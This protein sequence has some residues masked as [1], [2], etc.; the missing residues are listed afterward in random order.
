MLEPVGKS[1]PSR[2]IR[3]FVILAG[4]TFGQCVLYGPSLVG[5]K[6]LLPLDILAQQNVYTPRTPENSGIEAQNPTLTDNVYVY[7]P[8]RHFLSSELRAGRLPM[9]APFQ[10]G[11]VPFIW[12][13]FSPFL[14]LQSCVS[15]PGVL[16]WVQLLSALV[17]GAGAYLFFRRVLS[18]SFWPAAF[19]AWCYPLTGFFVF[20]LGCPTSLPVCW[21]PWLFLMVHFV[22]HRT[23]PL[24]PVGLALTTGLVLVSGFPDVAAQVLLGSGLFGLWQCFTLAPKHRFSFDVVKA[25]TR[26]AACW[27]LGFLVAAPYLLPVVEYS[28]T[29]SRMARRGAGNEERPPIG[30]AAVPQ[31]VLPDMYGATRAGTVRSVSDH[32]AESTAA[33]YA[34]VLATL[35]V[36]PL[37]FCSKRHLRINLFW[38]ALCFFGLAWCANVPGLVQLLRLPGLNMMSHNRLVFLASFAIISL[39]AIGLDALRLGLVT[40]KRWVWVPIGLLGCLCLWSLYCIMNLPEPIQTQLSHLILQGKQFG[41]VHDLEGVERVQNWFI[42]YYSMAAI[43]CGIGL[44][45][46]FL[47][48]RLQ[49]QPASIVTVFGALM[50]GDLLW[51]G[52]GRIAQCAPNLY[53]PRIPA[54]EWVANSGPGRIMGYGCLPATLSEMAGLN[55]IRGHDAVEP[56]RMVELITL[57]SEGVSLMPRYA[58]TMQV[59]PKAIIAPSGEFQLSPIMAMLGL[60]YVVLRGSPPAN[61]SP[62][63]RGTDYWIMKNPGAMARV[64][65]PKRVELVAD[66]KSRLQKMSA[67]SFNP[68]EIAYVEVPVNLPVSCIG[69]ASVTEAVPTQITVNA[70][71]ETPGLVVLA[72]RWDKGWRAYLDGKDEPILIANHAIRGVVV[73]AG[74]HRLVFRYQPASF[75]WGLRMAGLAALLILCWFAVAMWQRKARMPKQNTSP[76]ESD[77]VAS[78]VPPD[79]SLDRKVGWAS[80]PPLQS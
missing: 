61:A 55:D 74:T 47:L 77:G 40:W 35:L 24:A 73:P 54:L 14:L 52:Y 71:M 68:A 63:F 60:R 7:E 8:N 69:K 49:I 6:V 26:L 1:E 79:K 39:A 18:V 33:A 75:T 62:D 32:P 67:S 27:G 25:A 31:V 15:S 16:P 78:P 10:F 11:G 34:G 43:W 4:I 66:S 44:L 72:D 3:V 22:V 46:W 57:A 29:G 70:Q 19:G 17:A 5:N 42:R 38:V 51:F 58:T 2:L 37:A 28:Q 65:V 76:V 20:W 36:A 45:G 56:A 41:W 59:A 21:L 80:R 50:F 30:L 53:F 48:R 23:S 12:P 13:K 64:F 9:W